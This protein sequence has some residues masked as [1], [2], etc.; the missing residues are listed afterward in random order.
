[1]IDFTNLGTEYKRIFQKDQEEFL[2]QIGK[3]ASIRGSLVQLYYQLLKVGKCTRIDDLPEA[4]KVELWTEARRISEVQEKNYLI[5][6][7]KALQ[8]F[9]AFIQL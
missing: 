5:E 4:E 9:G 2:K 3:F 8:G 6:V 1:M 7:C